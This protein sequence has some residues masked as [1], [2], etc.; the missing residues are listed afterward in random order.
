[1]VHPWFE[2]RCGQSW[3]EIMRHGSQRVGPIA[4]ALGLLTGSLP[5]ALLHADTLVLRDGTQVNGRLIEVRNN[6]IEFE[7]NRRGQSTMRIN[8]RDVR[9]IEFDNGYDGGNDTG[10]DR[11]PY[12]RPGRPGGDYGGQREREVNVQARERWYDTG[13]DLR[14]GQTIRFQA[15]GRVRWGPGRQDGPEGENNSP[16][17]PNRPIPSRPAA[18]LVGRIDNDSPFFIGSDNAP[19]RVRSSGRLYLMIND[20]VLEDNTG[21]FR[22]VIYY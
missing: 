17:N 19:I 3:S 8:R 1:M 22:V 9:R 14:G 12:D 16:H 7:P 13:I 10:Y 4:I 2:W 18:A 11:P 21:S 15:S 5:G 20:D 6:T